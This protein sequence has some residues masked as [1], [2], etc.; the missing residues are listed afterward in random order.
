MINR[1][2]K[3][4]LGSNNNLSV[5]NWLTKGYPR[6]FMY[7]RFGT[8]QGVASMNIGVFERQIALIKK[9]FNPLS[10][11]QFQGKL[12]SGESIPANSVML[13]ID[14]GYQDFFTYA[15]PVLKKY[16]MPATIFV[17]HNFL[18]G[19]TWLWPDKIAF[20]LRTC[21]FLEIDVSDG[22]FQRSFSLA[23]ESDLT[24][25]WSDIADYCLAIGQVRCLQFIDD[26]AGNLEVTLPEKPTGDYS[27]LSWSQAREMS[28]Q[29]IEIG[30]H[31]CNHAR[32]TTVTDAALV[33]EVVDSKRLTE[34]ALDREVS[35]FAFP[36]GA[37]SDID[38]RT[39]Q[40]VRDA[41]YKVAFAAYFG[42]NYGKD[43]FEINRIPAAENWGDFVK[44]IHGRKVLEGAYTRLIG[45]SHAAF[46]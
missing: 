11:G 14:D 35:S 36:F 13:T 12:E 27:A 41:G 20:I 24:K 23:S 18:E 39:K 33:H 6:I 1:F 22:L 19:G 3:S 4:L 45:A 30:A 15:F 7:H 29:G 21:R 26:L 8:G 37:R 46:E 25:A 43:R 5:L 42:N 17:T 44:D 31:T 32:L 40:V 38:A 2:A 34:A 9:N 16:E 28:R 10:L